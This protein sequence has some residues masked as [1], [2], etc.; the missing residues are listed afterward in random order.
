MLGLNHRLAAALSAADVCLAWVQRRI[1][2]ILILLPTRR[3]LAR[4]PNRA[5]RL[6]YLEFAAAIGIF[7]LVAI[8]KRL[9]VGR[10]SMADCCTIVM[11]EIS[12]GNP[13]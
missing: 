9:L 13:G 6:R 11:E 4:R 5:R 10:C 1:H 12:T 2:R 8:V 3:S 7:A